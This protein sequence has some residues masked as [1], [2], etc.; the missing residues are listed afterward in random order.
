MRSLVVP[1]KL[2]TTNLTC[3]KPG[4]VAGATWD[5]LQDYHFACQPRVVVRET[6]ITCVLGQSVNIICDVSGNRYYVTLHNMT[7]IQ[8]YLSLHIV[9]QSGQVCK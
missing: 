6:R 2:S 9:T 4:A 7:I 3:S 1:H 8:C 5:S